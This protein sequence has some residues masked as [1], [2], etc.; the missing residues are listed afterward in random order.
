MLQLQ[1]GALLQVK[2]PSQ[3]CIV[4]V[5]GSQPPS[6]HC[7]EISALG[8]SMGPLKASQWSAPQPASSEHSAL[9]PMPLLAQNPPR[10]DRHRHG[11]WLQVGSAAAA[12]GAEG[13][14]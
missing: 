1:D 9:T 7:L 5:C 6:L 8:C 14:W 3:V 10:N 2:L 12:A 4:E 11:G 13:L